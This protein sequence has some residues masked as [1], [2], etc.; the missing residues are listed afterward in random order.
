MINIQNS[1]SDKGP[2]NSTCAYCGVG[3]GVTV[4]VTAE[5]EVSVKGNINHPSNTGRLCSKG[6]SLGETLSLEGRLL[7]PMVEGVPT[8]WDVALNKTA[9]AFQSTIEKY[10]PNA[11]AMYVSGQILTEDYYVANKF[12]KGF[13]GSS[14]IDTNSRLCMSTAVSGHKRAF[15]S[16]TVPGCYEDLEQTDLLLVVGSNM[17]WTH[18]IIYQRILRAKASRPEMKV[19]LIDPRKTA[20]A[21]IA[22]LHLALKPGTDAH[23]FNGLLAALHQRD[24]LNE[25]YIHNHTEG[26]EH[27]INAVKET[28]L[29]DT[30]KACDIATKDLHRLVEW[31]RHKPRMVTLF[32]QGINQSSSGVD[33]VSSIINLH[34]ATGRI[35]TPG[36][37]PFSITGQPNAMGGRE[38]GGLANQ[39]AAHMGFDKTSVDRVKRFWGAPNIVEKEGFK[40]LDLFKAIDRREIRAVWIVSTN[41]VVSL[42]DADFVRAALEKCDFVA[43]SECTL[44]TDTNAVADVLLPATAWGEKTGTVTNSER[45]ISLQKPFLPIPGMAKPDWW[46]ICEVA[47]RMGFEK[48]FDYS[49]PAEI[50]REHASLSGFENNGS[51]NFDI[52]AASTLADHQYNNLAPF[53]WPSVKQLSSKPVRMFANGNFY[54]PSKR[55]IFTPIIPRAPLSEI[56]EATPFYLNTGRIRDQWHTMTRSG[57]TSRLTSH[58]PEPFVE[59]NPEDATALDLNDGELVEICNAQGRVICRLVCTDSQRRGAL[60]IPIH[61]TNQQASAARVDVLVHANADPI[62][63]QPEYKHSTVSIKKYITSWEGFV[64]SRDDMDM[65]QIDYWCKVRE[66]GCFRYIIA[67]NADSKHIVANLSREQPETNGRQYLEYED[68]NKGIYRSLR[69][70]QGKLTSAIFISEGQQRVAHNWLVSKFSETSISSAD[71]RTLLSGRSVEPSDDPGR[72]ICSCYSVGIN[73]IKKA[74]REQSI[75]TVEGVGQCLKAGTNCG[76]CQSEIAGILSAME[77][78]ADTG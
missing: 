13:V 53:Y 18:P 37:G 56:T 22:D 27:C 67:G 43:V 60:F 17:A 54:T 31:M 23:L 35:G 57:K 45:C 70:T 44:L 24:A 10:G 51:R 71:R 16:D 33:K 59:M 66:N 46:M 2:I 12:M 78:V 9:A 7:S 50:F 4:S 55:A 39:L 28:S 77:K 69:L 73:T 36:S 11:V 62:S 8:S 34:L 15:G 68:Q 72:I 61:W 64:L 21:E 49:S 42:P 19:V 1:S 25:D 52:T 41:P 76:S 30:A 6:S 38:V 48:P 29:Q 20:T 63:G 32:S 40:A 47:K 75:T 26:F 58:R 3:C 14:N 74:I 5:S 65:S